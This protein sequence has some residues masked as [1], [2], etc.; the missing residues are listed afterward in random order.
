MLVDAL[1]NH[2]ID[3]GVHVL[4]IED[5]C[6]KSPKCNSIVVILLLSDLSCS[7]SSVIPL[8]NAVIHEKQTTPP[9]TKTSLW[10]KF[11]SIPKHEQIIDISYSDQVLI[12][13]HCFLLWGYLMYYMWEEKHCFLNHSSVPDWLPTLCQALYW[14]YT[15]GSSFVLINWILQV[16]VPRLV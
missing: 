14:D 10:G 5:C 3:L 1:N 16:R 9:K 11:W 4:Q 13:S 8:Q 12:I 15:V 7:F 2:Y 6:P